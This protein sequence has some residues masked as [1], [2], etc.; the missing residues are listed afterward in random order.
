MVIL[1]GTVDT[2]IERI[3]AGRNAFE[4]GA[5]DVWNKI[6]VRYNGPYSILPEEEE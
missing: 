3:T 4:A 5:K 6:E 1:D 2:W